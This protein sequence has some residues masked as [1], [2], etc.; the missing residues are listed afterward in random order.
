[1]CKKRESQADAFKLRCQ[2]SG[3]KSDTGL[4][5]SE[6]VGETSGWSRYGQGSYISYVI[7]LGIGVTWHS[8]MSNASK[9]CHEISRVVSSYAKPGEDAST[10]CDSTK[11]AA[12]TLV[13]SITLSSLQRSDPP[14]PSKHRE[15]L[16]PQRGGPSWEWFTSARNLRCDRSLPLP[17]DCPQ[18]IP[19]GKPTPASKLAFVNQHHNQINVFMTKSGSFDSSW[20]HQPAS[21]PLHPVQKEW[22]GMVN[23]WAWNQ[24]KAQE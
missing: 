23:K 6:V 17:Q 20:W 5:G 24:W 19:K 21:P 3:T 18:Y 8:H 4:G 2:N 13:I 12:C 16:N 15:G 1:M 14:P 9:G 22:Q 7:V 11:L 10:R